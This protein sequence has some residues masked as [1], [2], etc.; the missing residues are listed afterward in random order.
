MK[1]TFAIDYNDSTIRTHPLNL[2]VAEKINGAWQ[3]NTD[4]TIPLDMLCHIDTKLRE[5]HLKHG[6][7]FHL[8]Q[9]LKG[10]ECESVEVP[11][12]QTACLL[13]E[14]SC[15]NSEYGDIRSILDENLRYPHKYELELVQE[16]LAEHCKGA[17]FDYSFDVGWGYEE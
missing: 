16:Y 2:L 7:I 9:A 5:Y 1:L 10:F 11:A 17:C 4:W 12:A 3:V 13:I 14:L 15:I 8:A 6:T